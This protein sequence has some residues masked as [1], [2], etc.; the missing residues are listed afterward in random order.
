MSG[1][2]KAPQSKS[3]AIRLILYSLLSNVILN[4]L[5][6]SEDTKVAIDV[7]KDIGVNVSDNLSLKKGEKLRVPQYLNFGGSATTL[8]MM[9]PILSVLGGEVVLDGNESLRRRPI[10]AIVEALAGQIRFSSNY[11]PVTMTGKLKENYVRIRGDESSQYISGFIYA[12]SLVNGG[13]IEIIP[14]LSSKSYIHM[15]IDL[16]NAL[17]GSVKFTGNR[18]RVERGEFRDFR[19]DVP[20]DYALASFYAIASAITGGEIQIKGLYS[21]PYYD[22]DHSI[23]KIIKNMGVDSRVE[24]NSWIVSGNGIIKGIK[25]DVD[26][27]PDLAPS[28][29]C[30]APF[31]TSETEIT[32]IKRLRIKES[33]RVSTI[34]ST[35]EAF[36]GNVVVDTDFIKIFPSKLTE[37]SIICPNDH[38]IA[39]MA[40]VISLRTGGTVENAQCVNK[41]NPSFWLDLISLGG[42]IH[43]T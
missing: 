34:K 14:P 30:I 41:S 27:M 9:I 37:G 40:G 31:A 13:D 4:N 39:M 16:I 28:I 6:L 36:S 38:R 26:D 22:G 3:L 20:G 29:A 25:V 21:P 18:I 2:I 33:D 11:L 5:S 23:V 15:T 19:G 42:D 7:V 10:T 17:G 35:L 24:G 8:R 12:F 1:I 32:G 43:F